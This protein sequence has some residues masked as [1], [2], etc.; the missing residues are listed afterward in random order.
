MDGSNALWAAA[1]GFLMVVAAP[2]RARAQRSIALPEPSREGTLTIE[3]SLQTRRSV[4][5]FAQEP[6]QLKEV[7]Q[8]AWAAQ[9]VTSPDGLRTAPS[10]GAL[11][12]LEI[13]VVANRVED[14]P[15]GIYRY[16]P[17]SHALVRVAEASATQAK[18]LARAAAEQEFVGEAPAVFVISAVERRT[19]AKYGPRARQ[20]VLLEAGCAIENLALQA[21]ALDLGSVVVGAFDERAVASLLQ[22]EKAEEPLALVP[23]G[24]PRRSG[25]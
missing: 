15:R 13:L 8:L 12:P 16:V 17:R 20:Y 23:V 6:L 21:V 2:T 19:A 11:Y 25:G 10:A 14:L 1:I 22:L 24:H 7:G 4:R 5:E 9:G 3:K 18:E